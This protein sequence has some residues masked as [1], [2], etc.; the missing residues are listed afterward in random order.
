MISK[1]LLEKISNAVKRARAITHQLLG[2][3]RKHEPVVAEVDLKELAQETLHL[4]RKEAANKEIQLIQTAGENLPPIWI[5]PNQVRQILINLL[6]NAIH[7]TGSQGTISVHI[8]ADRESTTLL[9]RDT[10]KGIPKENMK[11]IFEPLFQR[12]TSGGKEPDW[13]FS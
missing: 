10:G 2:S 13:A 11:K 3:V 9:I 6:T 1:R 8:E 12:Q 5:D 7:A 4:V